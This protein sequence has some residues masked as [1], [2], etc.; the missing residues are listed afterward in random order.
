[1]RVRIVL[2]ISSGINDLLL[3]ES[4]YLMAIRLFVLAATDMDPV[5]AT[6]YSFHDEL[7]EIRVG[8]EP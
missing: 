2:R 8:L 3:G 4:L 1:M 7:V 6:V 5:V